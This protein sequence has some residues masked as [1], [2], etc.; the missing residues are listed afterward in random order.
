MT[1]SPLAD[2]LGDQDRKQ[3]L[4][5]RDLLRAGQLCIADGLKQVEV[6]QKGKKEKK[7]GYL[8]WELS[9]A[10]ES[11]ASNVRDVRYNGTILGVLARL[12]S[13]TTASRRGQTLA[14]QKAEEVR[15]TDVEPL[16]FKSGADVGQGRSLAA[17]RA[18]SLVDCVTFWRCPTTGRDGGEERIYVGVAGEVVDDRS[19]GAD[20]K[21]KPL[22]DVIGGCGFMEVST[23]DLV[24]PVGRRIRLL[25]QAREFWGAS[26]WS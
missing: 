2:E 11:Q 23:A 26:H 16:L 22:G 10:V 14:S 4:Q 9:P 12:G 13:R 20:M 18:G 6:K 15:F 24:V 19:N 3:R 7:A 8:G 21:M 25:E 5:R 17:K 1:D